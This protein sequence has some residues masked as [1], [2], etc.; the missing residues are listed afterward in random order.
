MLILHGVNA[1]KGAKDDLLRAVG[2]PSPTSSASPPGASTWCGC[3]S[4]GT[5]SSQ[6]PVSTTGRNS[7]ASPSGC[8]GAGTPGFTFSYDPDA[9]AFEL[10]FDDAP[11][12]SGATR[13][14]L[15]ARRLYAGGW[16]LIVSDP[17]GTWSSSFDA[18]RQR[19]TLVTGSSAA[20]HTVR[21]TPSAPG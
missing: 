16:E 10:V 4:C 3:W 5:G 15:P 11:D 17:A 7:S 13:I 2:P 8:G 21:I 9:R 19:L 14:V 20:R 6:R 1:N 12:V 18:T